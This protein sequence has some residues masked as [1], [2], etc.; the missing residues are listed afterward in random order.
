MANKNEMIV[1]ATKNGVHNKFSRKSWESIKPDSQGTRNGWVEVT[2]GDK[3]G[4]PQPTEITE[5]LKKGTPLK[6]QPPVIAAVEKTQD[7]KPAEIKQEVKKNEVAAVK[8]DE[9]VLVAE[10]IK[11]GRPQ[12]K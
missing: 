2:D 3:Y 5:F 12:K 6:T 8:N 4:I 9:P 10:K 11:R 1:L 7:V